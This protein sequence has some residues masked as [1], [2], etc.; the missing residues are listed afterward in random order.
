MMVKGEFRMTAVTGHEDKPTQTVDHRGRESLFRKVRTTE[1][2][3]RQNGLKGDSETVREFRAE[4]VR[5]N[6]KL[7]HLKIINSRDNEDMFRI[8]KIMVY[9]LSQG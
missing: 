8:K 6:K 3:M 4:L 7:N 9:Y 2:L 5:S 1:Y